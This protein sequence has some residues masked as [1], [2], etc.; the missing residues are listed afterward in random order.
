MAMTA[1]ACGRPDVARRELEAAVAIA[2]RYRHPLT[3]NDCVVACGVIATMDGRLERAS[4]LLS[5]VADGGYVR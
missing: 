5:A 4:V 3:L 2:R 1:T